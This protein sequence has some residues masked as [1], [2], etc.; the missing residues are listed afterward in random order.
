MV[1]FRGFAIP[2]DKTSALRVF[3]RRRSAF[4]CFP[5]MSCAEGCHQGAFGQAYAV[6]SSI[7]LA[8]A[9]NY[10]KSANEKAGLGSALLKCSPAAGA[11]DAHG[12][13]DVVG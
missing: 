3:C 9:R 5:G 1:L 4:H 12:K 7:A 2:L 10:F 13:G 8:E 11:S 6:G